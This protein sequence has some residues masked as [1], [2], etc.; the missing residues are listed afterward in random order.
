MVY[1]PSLEMCRVT[2][3]PCRLLYNTSYFP[4]FMRCNETLFPS[5][6]NNDV[7]E[8]RFNL[9]G[10]CLEPL[11]PA[12][13]TIS[14]HPGV[15]GCGVRCKDPLYT[16]DEH[17]QI[18]KLTAWGCGLCFLA[19]LFVVVTFLIDWDNASKYPALIVFYIN[20]CFLIACLG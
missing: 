5:K 16:D 12:E 9:T 11:V 8:M 17:R 14:Y 2:L 19:N 20:F 18:Q 6:C 7:R 3:E 1:L 4:E 13:S 10:Q 15:E